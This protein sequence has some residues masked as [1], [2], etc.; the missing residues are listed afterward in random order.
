[1]KKIVLIMVVLGLAVAGI[2]LLLRSCDTGNATNTPATSSAKYEVRAD[3]RIYYTNSYSQ[4]TDK[5]GKYIDLLGYWF[6]DGNLWQYK[7]ESLYLSYR[8]YKDI[9]IIKR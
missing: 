4:G 7:K 6:Y 5:N 8:G 2:G 3:N 9:Q 1:M